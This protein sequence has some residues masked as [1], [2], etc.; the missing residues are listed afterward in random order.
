MAGGVFI[1][2]AVQASVSFEIH[3]PLKACF[4]LRVFDIAFAGDD[5]S[6]FRL[7]KRA[8]VMNSFAVVVVLTGQRF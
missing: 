2:K 1:R 6:L 3:F 4:V 8:D 7:E 5:V